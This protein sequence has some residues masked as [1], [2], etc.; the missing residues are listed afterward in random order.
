M[1]GDTSTRVRLPVIVAVPITPFES[2]NVPLPDDVVKFVMVN[3]LIA[4]L[5][6]TAES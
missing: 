4:P 1:S 6:R 5:S 3:E 2:V